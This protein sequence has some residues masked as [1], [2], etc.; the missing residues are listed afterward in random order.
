MKKT[1]VAVFDK[2]SN[3]FGQPI[4]APA[5]GVALRSFTDE[6]NKN[7]ENNQMYHHPDDFTLYDLGMFDDN[8]GHFELHDQPKQLLTAKDAKTPI[9]S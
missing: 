9:A 1:I 4:F 8:T 6:V 7:Y 2:A 3:A 5:K